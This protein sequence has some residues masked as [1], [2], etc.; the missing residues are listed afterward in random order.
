[1]ILKQEVKGYTFEKPSKSAKQV[2]M[3]EISFPIFVNLLYR[4]N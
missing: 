1:M 2:W 3:E 4:L